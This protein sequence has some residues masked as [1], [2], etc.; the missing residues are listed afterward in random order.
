MIQ[1]FDAKDLDDDIL[2]RRLQKI[3]LKQK[4]F[5]YKFYGDKISSQ[6]DPDYPLDIITTRIGSKT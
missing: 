2:A 5:V 3:L 6:L 4:G 1:E